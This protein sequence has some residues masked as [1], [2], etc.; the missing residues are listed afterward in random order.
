MDNR[1]IFDKWLR[2][3][4]IKNENLVSDMENILNKEDPLLYVHVTNVDILNYSVL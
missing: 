4:I 3:E 2:E 1:K